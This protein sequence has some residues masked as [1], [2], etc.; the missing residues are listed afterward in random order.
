MVLRLLWAQKRMFW[1]FEKSIFQFFA[2]F[3]LTKLKPFSGKARLSLQDY[4]N[5]KF[6]IRSLLENGSEATLRSKT[7]VLSI[8]KKIS[9]FW[10]FRVTK[11]IPLSWKVRQDIKKCLHQNLVIISFLENGFDVTLSS[12][13]N[14][15]S[16]WKGNFS[17]FCKFLSDENETVFW[18][19]ETKPSRPSKFKVGHKKLFKKRFWIDLE[20]KNEC[21]KH[22][23][24][25]VFRFL[26]FLSDKV[27]NIFWESEKKNIKNCLNQNLVIV[28]FLE[29][30]FEASL[31]S[32]TNIVS[33]WK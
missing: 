17:D 15:L 30:S 6:G 26:Q 7:N 11:L 32:R 4:L 13:K 3:C 22:L 20:I 10:N 16:I 23:K 5:S 19:C 8:W 9:V 24:R 2:N 14:V 25:E 1:V 31:I 27:E 29:N 12:E 18:E 21:S 33:V 28:T